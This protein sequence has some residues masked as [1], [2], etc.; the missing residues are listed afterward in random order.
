MAVSEHNES[1]VEWERKPT[2]HGQI[3]ERLR[4]QILL[5]D[6]KEGDLLPSE[7]ELA[8]QYDVSRMPVRV[9]LRILE[10]LGVIRYVRKK[11]MV[12]QRMDPGYFFGSVAPLMLEVDSVASD[13]FHVRQVIEPYAVEL[14]A[15]LRG[16]ENLTAM[17]ES[18]AR[19]E[20]GMVMKESVEGPSLDFHTDIVSA[21]QNKVL[22]MINLFLSELERVARKKSFNNRAL[23]EKALSYHKNIYAKILE[24]DVAG[25][26]ALMREHLETAHEGLKKELEKKVEEKE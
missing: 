2:L 21:S 5:G 13:L 16:E 9:A 23:Q 8:E 1:S 19:M 14:A 12:V 25:A 11:G 18:I 4:E 17:R 3:V 15:S 26:S 10:Y 22:Q 20:K 24:H 6:F 7:R